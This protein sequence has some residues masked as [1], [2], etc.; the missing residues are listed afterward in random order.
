MLRERGK[1][2]C[3][4]LPFKYKKATQALNFFAIKEGGKINKMKALKLIFFADRFHLR[5]YGKPILNDEYFAMPYGP[6]ASGTKD[7]AEF[8]SYLS[9]DAREYATDFIKLLEDGL[10]L[11]SKSEYNQ[12]VF[13]RSDLEAL[14]FAWGKFGYI[15]EFPIS[16]VTHKYP[17]WKRHEAALKKTTRVKMSY[18]DFFEDPLEPEEKC[19]DLTMEEKN[20]RLSYVKEISRI[21]AMLNC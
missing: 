8:T 12:K 18:E 11:L 5:K 20:E 3:I 7:I 14:E 15:E 9:E 10:T 19:F 1:C 4:H 21:E 16:D 17:E 6:V 13:S 2:M